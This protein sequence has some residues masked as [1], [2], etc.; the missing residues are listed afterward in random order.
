M[1][2]TVHCFDKVGFDHL[3]FTKTDETN[4][5]GPLLAILVKTGKSLAYITNGQKVPDDFRKAS[6]QFF[7]ARLFPQ[8]NAKESVFSDIPDADL[9]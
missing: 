1:L 8:A 5:F 6:F 3:I 9:F 7:N 4:T 2:E